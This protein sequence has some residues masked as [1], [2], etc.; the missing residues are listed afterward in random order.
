MMGTWEVLVE[1]QEGA[2]SH[3]EEE[4]ISNLYF[5]ADIVF[6]EETKVC[7]KSVH[8]KEMKWYLDNGRP[9]HMIE[10]ILV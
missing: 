3:K 1:E 8:Q 4:I 10:N 7:L 2:K 9:R 6:D 5:M